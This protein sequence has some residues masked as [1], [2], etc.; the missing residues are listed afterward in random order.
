ML[1]VDAMSAVSIYRGIS[2]WQMQKLK[3]KLNQISV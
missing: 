3:I 2:T 1:T